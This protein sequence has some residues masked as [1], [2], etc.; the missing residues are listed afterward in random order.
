MVANVFRQLVSV[1]TFVT[2]D[3]GSD[4]FV[5]IQR[6]ERL[7]GL[8]ADC[9]MDPIASGRCHGRHYSFKRRHGS[10]RAKHDRVARLARDE[11]VASMI[12]VG[13]IERGR[14]ERDVREFELIVVLAAAG[15]VLP[16]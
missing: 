11:G 14:E 9:E 2:E 5:P 8:F 6:L 4:R 13:L 15:R 16:R 3:D 12:E 10:L 7:S 1:A